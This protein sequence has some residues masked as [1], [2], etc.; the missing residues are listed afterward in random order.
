MK[1][2]TKTSVTGYREMVEF[3][4]E[5]RGNSNLILAEKA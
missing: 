5:F 4:E 2:N 1:K 3:T